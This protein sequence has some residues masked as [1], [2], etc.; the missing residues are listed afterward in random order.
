MNDWDHLFTCLDRGAIKIFKKGTDKL[1]VILEEYN[2]EPDIQNQYLDPFSSFGRGKIHAPL[3]LVLP[4]M[5]LISLLP[6]L[7]GINI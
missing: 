3:L 2:M 6:E 1:K 7:R 4:T 5:V